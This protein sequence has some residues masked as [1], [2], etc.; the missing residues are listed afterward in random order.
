[1][2]PIAI[3][4]LF[5]TIFV[6][7]CSS[8]ENQ[9]SQQIELSN[10]LIK[11]KQAVIDTAMAEK[12]KQEQI[13]NAGKLYLEA[14]NSGIKEEIKQEVK[15]EEKATFICTLDGE[16]MEE[17]IEDYPSNYEFIEECWVFEWYKACYVR[18]SDDA[19]CF[20]K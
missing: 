6:S 4:I 10:K 1:M 3:V 11:E 17:P 15:Q 5:F 14:L 13:A 16:N 12:R 20:K 9:V 19:N 7:W 8:I 2:K 18:H